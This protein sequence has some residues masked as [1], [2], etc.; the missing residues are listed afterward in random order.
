MPEVYEHLDAFPF[1]AP[2]MVLRRSEEL[3]L[4]EPLPSRMRQ[5]RERPPLEAVHFPPAYIDQPFVPP[6]GVYESASVRIE[7]QTMDARQPFYHRNCGVDE[8]SF[9][10]CGDRTIMT[11]LGSVDVVPGEFA[12][13]PDG[14]AHDNRGVRDIH[15]LFY[16]PGPVER[17][18]PVHRTA[19]HRMPP[20]PGWTPAVINEL[21][22]EGVAGPGQDVVMAPV[23]ERMLLDHAAETDERL[24]VL[25]PAGSCTVWLYRCPTIMIGQV[26]ADASDGKVYRRLR[27]AEEIQYQVAGTRT[28]VTQRGVLRLQPGDFVRIPRALASTSIHVG[29]STHLSMVSTQP[30]PQVAAGTRQAE[31]LTPEQIAALRTTGA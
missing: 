23:D 8:I 15:L 7:W 28:L 14:V 27:N 6:R 13:L 9:Q 26:A 29:P 20:F 17:L 19:E 25:R 1:A 22:T 2:P 30:V 21:V 10:V 4:A 31:R 18:G 16:V 3:L 11:E 12:R 24:E 5:D